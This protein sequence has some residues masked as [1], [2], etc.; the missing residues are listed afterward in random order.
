[1]TR[2]VYIDNGVVMIQCGDI[3]KEYPQYVEKI[4]EEGKK[5]LIKQE[6]VD[7]EEL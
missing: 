1:M 3:I 5:I 2:E 7:L 6:P 4:D